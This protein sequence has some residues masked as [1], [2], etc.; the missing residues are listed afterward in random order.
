MREMFFTPY[1][2]ILDPTENRIA[3]H[4]TILRIIHVKVGVIT[5]DK[6]NVV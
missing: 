5:C 3:V 2:L 6:Y 4:F 1:M